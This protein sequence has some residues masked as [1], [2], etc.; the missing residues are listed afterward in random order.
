MIADACFYHRTLERSNGTFVFGNRFTVPTGS[1]RWHS[2]LGQREYTRS[3]RAVEARRRLRKH[4]RQATWDLTVERM[5]ESYLNCCNPDYTNNRDI[6]NYESD[7]DSESSFDLEDMDAAPDPEQWEANHRAANRQ[8]YMEW[9]AK[10]AEL[11]C[12]NQGQPAGRNDEGTSPSTLMH[13]LHILPRI[14]SVE[15]TVNDDD[16]NDSDSTLDMQ[17]EIALAHEVTRRCSISTE[18]SADVAAAYSDAEVPAAMDKA[19]NDITDSVAA[20]LKL[21]GEHVSRPINLVTEDEMNDH[22]LLRRIKYR[23]VRSC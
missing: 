17:Q 18:D 22:E 3:T 13:N 7:H 2:T 11:R 12:S 4:R 1:F 19:S 20:W 15:S 6:S 21:R 10:Q 16:H 9:L 8:P 23:Y 5:F 14:R